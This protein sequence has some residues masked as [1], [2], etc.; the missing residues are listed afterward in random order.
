L[1]PLAWK[2]AKSSIN[3][4]KQDTRLSL[5]TGGSFPTVGL[6]SRC[7]IYRLRTDQPRRPSRLLSDPEHCI[8]RAASV[9]SPI[10]IVGMHP[11]LRRD[12][13]LHHQ[14]DHVHRRRMSRRSAWSVFQRRLTFPDRRTALPA[15]G[16]ELDAGASLAAMALDKCCVALSHTELW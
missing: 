12:L 6:S 7:D 8:F 2:H 13:A 4:R 15:N 14:P 9:L 3:F 16:I 10:I 11:S 1:N 5:K